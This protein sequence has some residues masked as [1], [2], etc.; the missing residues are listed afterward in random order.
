[1]TDGKRNHETVVGG[2][3]YRTEYT[4]GKTKAIQRQNGELIVF[5]SQN[6]DRNPKY[7]KHRRTGY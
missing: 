5:R 1:M 6:G 2:D 7:N 3:V 4:G